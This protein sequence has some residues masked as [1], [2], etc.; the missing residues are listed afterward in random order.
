MSI[1]IAPCPQGDDGSATATYPTLVAHDCGY[2][3]SRYTCRATRV[4]ADFLDFI[5]FC[6]CSSGCR[7]TPPKKFGV[8]PFP[9]P[10]PGGV[11]PKFGSEKVSRYTGVS[12]LQL[13]VSRYTV[14]L[15]TPPFLARKRAAKVGVQ[16][17]DQSSLEVNSTAQI[18]GCS[19]LGTTLVTPPKPPSRS[20]TLVTPIP[21][22]MSNIQ[23]TLHLRSPCTCQPQPS[24]A[25]WWTCPKSAP[26][27]TEILQML[28]HVMRPNAGRAKH[29][30]ADAWTD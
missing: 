20:A 24:E 17:R 9:P 22:Q 15:S 28:V 18:K 27:N 21:P 25:F 10:F 6:R 14:Q 13:R 3:L 29:K 5:A 1:A 7:A 23:H 30:R 26:W 16:G 11:A 2:P 4:A 12:Q 19:T 8:A